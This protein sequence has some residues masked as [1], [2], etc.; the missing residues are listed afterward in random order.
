MGGKLGWQGVKK[1]QQNADNWVD[2]TYCS[3][4]KFLKISLRAESKNYNT[5]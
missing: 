2:I 4:L 1:S 5:A 3:S